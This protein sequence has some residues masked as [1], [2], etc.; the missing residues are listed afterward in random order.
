MIENAV[1]STVYIRLV[2]TT[3]IVAK[4]AV[5]AIL[6][7]G[8]TSAHAAKNEGSDASGAPRRL[9]T[10]A[11]LKLAAPVRIRAAAADESDLG[12]ASPLCGGASSANP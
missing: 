2:T 11:T 1:S 6:L 12:G 9:A 8:S 7:A 3:S 10:H 5:C 4:L